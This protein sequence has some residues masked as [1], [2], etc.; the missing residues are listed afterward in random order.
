MQL[1]GVNCN[2]R[3]LGENTAK[4]VFKLKRLQI[5]V[6][7][8]SDLSQNDRLRVFNLFLREELVALAFMTSVGAVAR[9]RPLDACTGSDF[10]ISK[11]L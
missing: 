7:G 11:A 3:S 2:W 10:K 4:V 5:L 1:A 6:E 8:V 9:T